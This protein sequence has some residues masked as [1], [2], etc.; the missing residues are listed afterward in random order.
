MI[1]LLDWSGSMCDL[2]NKTVHQLC[3]LVWFC[4]KINIPF[5]VY[6]FKDTMDKKNDPKEYFKFKNGNMFAE[7][8]HLVN[9]VSIE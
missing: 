5:E 4:Q 8:S 6:L 3:N 7:N 9:V 2:M 1:M